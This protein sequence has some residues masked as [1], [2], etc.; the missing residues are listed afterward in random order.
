MLNKGNDRLYQNLATKPGAKNVKRAD[1]NPPSYF[2]A[3]VRKHENH[4]AIALNEVLS[5]KLVCYDVT[6]ILA[7]TLSHRHR[8]NSSVSFPIT[9]PVYRYYFATIALTAPQSERIHDHC[10]IIAMTTLL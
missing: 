2:S 7:A 10:H 6:G 4:T 1:R 9:F 5:C 3:T 8:G